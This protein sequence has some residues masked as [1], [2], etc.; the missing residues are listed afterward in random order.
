MVGQIK[1]AFRNQLVNDT[2][3]SP[4]CI[5]YL[6]AEYGPVLLRGESGQRLN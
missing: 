4:G 1:T 6:T 2:G 5:V 3:G